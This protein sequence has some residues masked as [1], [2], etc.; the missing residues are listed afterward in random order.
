MFKARFKSILSETRFHQLLSHFFLSLIVF[1]Q[2]GANFNIFLG[3]A[4]ENR[5]L[6]HIS[7]YL[8]EWNKKLTKIFLSTNLLIYFKLIFINL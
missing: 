1:I 6:D 7:L 3:I 4:Q 5:S 8:F 2:V